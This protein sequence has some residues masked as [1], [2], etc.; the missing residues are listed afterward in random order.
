MGPRVGTVEVREVFWRDNQQQWLGA[1][2]VAKKFPEPQR[3][4]DG[5]YRDGQSLGAGATG[6]I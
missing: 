5:L 1:G 6:M 2:S 4:G 3:D